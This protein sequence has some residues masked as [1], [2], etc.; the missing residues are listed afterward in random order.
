[1]ST[2]LA[3]ICTDGLVLCAE[4]QVSQSDF[5]YYQCNVKRIALANGKGSVALG[6]AGQPADT[7]K[8]LFENLERRW[9]WEDKAREQIR[10][11]LQAVL[12]EVLR[13]DKGVHQL[14]CVFQD[15][16][17][18]HIFKT[19]NKG[20]WPVPV[21]DCIGF[22]DNALMRYLGAIFLE[23]VVHL[24]LRRAVP[25]CI[26]MVAQA[27]KYVPGSGGPTD[28]IVLSNSGQAIHKEFGPQFDTACDEVERELNCVLTSATE[29]GM[30]AEYVRR[31]IERMGNVLDTYQQA[32]Y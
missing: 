3:T 19:Y 8:T 10:T 1:M 31:L 25:I 16:E 26:Y 13:K 6:Y 29:P 30:T 17:G 14:L 28:L 24:P 11:E 12:D 4:Q 7:M 27:K 20:I 21:W 5:K 2:G 23:T 9:R 32:V 22:G 18:S 15:A